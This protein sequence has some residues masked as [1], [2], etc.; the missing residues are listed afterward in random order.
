[1]G[2][3][4]TIFLLTINIEA[5]KGAPYEHYILE[6]ISEFIKKKFSQCCGNS[7][8]VVKQAR[9]KVGSSTRRA[10]LVVWVK[11]PAGIWKAILI[12]CKNYEGSYIGNRTIDQI[13]DYKNNLKTCD[14]CDVDKVLPILCCRKTTCMSNAIYSK[15]TS[16]GIK[17]ESFDK[18]SFS[19]TTKPRVLNASEEEFCEM[20]GKEIEKLM[21][22]DDEL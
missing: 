10:D 19:D 20:L 1:M 14:G 2:S 8:Y 13:L 21:N 17:V 4:Y 12:E 16:N 22:D 7:P 11:S 6:L 18:D 5:G 9:I 3:S 15:L